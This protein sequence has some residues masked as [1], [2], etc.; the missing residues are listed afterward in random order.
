ME[1]A[2]PA[3]CISKKSNAL[4]QRKRNRMTDKLYSVQVI[5]EDIHHKKKEKTLW[6]FNTI[7]SAQG[8]ID[9][10]KEH[11]GTFEAQDFVIREW[12]KEREEDGC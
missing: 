4:N 1:E 12:T 8:L 7:E 2:A 10:L 11:Q 5:N 3:A 6:M 9:Y